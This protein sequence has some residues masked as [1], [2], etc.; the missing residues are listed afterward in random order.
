MENKGAIKLGIE[1][2]EKIQKSRRITLEKAL[3][4]LNFLSSNPAINKSAEI[5][6]ALRLGC[7][8]LERE[9]D[10][11]ERLG[12]ECTIPLPSETKE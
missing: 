3:E 11:R 5:Y 9:Q 2:L 4:L 12:P 8:A 6:P 1:A 7:E 10:Y